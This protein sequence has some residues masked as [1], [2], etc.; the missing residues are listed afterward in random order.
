MAEGLEWLDGQAASLARR[1]RQR[2]PERDRDEGTVR[3]PH[4]SERHDLL[5]HLHYRDS[6]GESSERTV[7]VREVF[8]REGIIYLGGHCHLREMTRVFRS[9][10]IELLANGRTGEVVEDVA[11]F[12]EGIAPPDDKAFATMGYRDGRPL[13]WTGREASALRQHT[14]PLAIMMMALAKADGVWHP[15]EVKVLEALVED[16]TG[17]LGL[18]PDIR[19]R[20]RLIGEFAAI[21]PSGNLLTRACKAVLADRKTYIDAPSWC[22]RMIEADGHTKPDEL[23]EYRAILTRLTEL[24]EEM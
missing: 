9:D 10:R 4:V 1:R 20:L 22:R 2:G 19:G 21:V 18:K 7:L 8:R 23:H 16:G 17:A 15:E 11:D 6:A 13:V 24:A 5:L 14:R 12:L 3:A